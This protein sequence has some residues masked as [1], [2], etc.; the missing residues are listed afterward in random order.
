VTDEGDNTV[1]E[2]DSAGD[3]ITT[4]SGAGGNFAG[5]NFV[6]TFAVPEPSAIALLMAGLGLLVYFTRRKAVVATVRS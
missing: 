1:S 5:P 6:T 2:Y 3:L 4:F